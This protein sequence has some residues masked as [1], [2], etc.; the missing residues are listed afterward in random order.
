MLFSSH[1]L[2]LVEHLCHAVAIIHRGKLVAHGTVAELAEAGQ[3]HVTVKVAGDEQARWTSALLPPATVE[4]VADGTATISLDSRDEAQA[5]LDLARRAGPVEYFGFARRRLSQV[6]R[7]AVGA[8]VNGVGQEH[9][10][11]RS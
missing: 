7:D 2:D 4:L 6:F 3:L 10:E 1:Q 11:A 8:D 9:A 5:V